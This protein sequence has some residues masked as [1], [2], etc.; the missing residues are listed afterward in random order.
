MVLV[1]S[2]LLSAAVRS[3]RPD[4]PSTPLLQYEKILKL[5]S[6]AKLGE[7]CCPGPNQGA[8]LWGREL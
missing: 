5:T 3:V 7:R 6:D 8:T 2:A 1:V 4:G